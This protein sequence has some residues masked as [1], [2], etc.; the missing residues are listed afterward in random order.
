MYVYNHSS[1][2]TGGH[3]CYLTISTF[4]QLVA[5]LSTLACLNVCLYI[6][7]RLFSHLSGVCRHIYLSVRPSVCLY[8]LFC[9]HIYLSARLSFSLYFSLSVCMYTY[10]T[11]YVIVHRYNNFSI[12][13]GLFTTTCRPAYYGNIYF[14]CEH[15]C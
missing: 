10:V 15:Q 11:V 3:I 7:S 9:L 1:N 14:L 4:V 8:T 12:C 5:S 6:S 13:T 2:Q